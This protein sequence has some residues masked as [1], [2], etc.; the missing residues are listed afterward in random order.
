MSLLVPT[1]QDRL[2][3]ARL[4]LEGLSVGDAFGERFFVTQTSSSGY[5]RYARCPRRP[6]RTPTILRWR[7]PL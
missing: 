7:F 6:G 2:E 3:R 1:R 5:S 4:S